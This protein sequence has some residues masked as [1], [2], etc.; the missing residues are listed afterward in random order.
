MIQ[1]IIM[2]LKQQTANKLT[3]STKKFNLYQSFDRYK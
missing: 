1:I 3:V 2:K